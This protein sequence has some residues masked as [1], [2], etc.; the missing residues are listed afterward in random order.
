MNR[1]SR[2]LTVA[3]ALVL[4]SLSLAV[5]AA[6]FFQPQP[7]VSR[8]TSQMPALVAAI[9]IEILNGL[10]AAHTRRK[11]GHRAPIIHRDVSPDNILLNDDSLPVLLD[12]GAARVVPDHISD[13]YRALLASGLAGDD[14]ALLDA[15]AGI[16]ILP[17]NAPAAMSET[18]V[19]MARDGFAPLR[20]DGPFDFERPVLFDEHGEIAAVDELHERGQERQGPQHRE[21]DHE[22]QS[23]ADAEHRTG[24]QPDRQH[25]FGGPQ[26]HGDEQR[27][28]DRRAGEQPD[29]D[30]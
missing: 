28:R 21:A 5:C 17:P 19:A 9:G 15:M 13:G 6:H 4:L 16:G 29:D 25:R 8:L 2:E 26:L 7:L 10:D 12:F 11:D 18:I 23:A 14:A 3:A 1:Y 24:E 30:G 22:T 20:L 27:Q